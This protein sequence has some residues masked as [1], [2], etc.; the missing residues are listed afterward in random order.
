MRRVTRL[1]GFLFAAATACAA[2]LLLT[3][4]PV[5]VADN[6]A[7]LRALLYLQA[8]QSP[9]DG[10]VPSFSDEASELY[11]IGAAAAGYDPQTLRN[12]GPS[13]VEYLETRTGAACAKSRPGGPTV[14]P[15]A[16]GRL[17]QA[18]VAAGE[19]PRAFGG[20][21]LVAR[22]LATYDSAHGAFG[23][24]DAFTQSLAIQGLL[25]AGQRVPA[26]AL[27]QLAAAQDPDGG[28]GFAGSSDTNST[29]MAL[30]TL[31]A[32]GVH[33]EDPAALAWLRSRQR[34]NGGYA[35]GA[36]SPVDPDSTAL[37]TQ[38]LTAA[39]QDPGG[40]AWARGGQTPAGWLA[41]AQRPDGGFVF[42]HTPPPDTDTT[43]QA[44]AGLERQAFPVHFSYAPGRALPPPGS[45][46]ST[47]TQAPVTPAGSPARAAGTR[48]SL[49]AQPTPAATPKTSAVPAAPSTTPAASGVQ[50]STTPGAGRSVAAVRPPSQ[51]SGPG[52]AL[53]ALVG[54]GALLL[55][56]GAGYLLMRRGARV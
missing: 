44:L 26:G 13:V 56:G 29:S 42:P 9:S 52:L 17:I 33:R 23:A 12:G 4:R 37:V 49:G 55:A 25:A 28:W 2:G 5:V 34:P 50:G 39:G 7:A 48:S 24:G 11:A 47:P 27:S 43:A 54:A 1:A 21:D 6:D 32:A 31:D 16:C 35:F 22:L 38:A 10:S 3:S 8:Q 15:G 41:A 51:A 46:T 19:T 30:M 18:V 53:Y 14:S 45:P 20:A 36:G 40:A